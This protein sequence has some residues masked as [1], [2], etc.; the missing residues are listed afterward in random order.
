MIVLSFDCAVQNLGV[1]CLQIDDKWKDKL[2][3][4][5][6]NLNNLKKLS[7]DNK[8]IVR[9]VHKA[10]DDLIAIYSNIVKIIYMN[11]VNL[12][13]NKKDKFSDV[14]KKLKYFLYCLDK[15][16]PEPNYVL[17]EKQWNVN[18]DSYS[19]MHYIEGYYTLINKADDIDSLFKEYPINFLDIKP[20]NKYEVLILSASI[21]NQLSIN[22]KLSYGNIVSNKLRSNNYTTNK[23]HTSANFKEYLKQKN[24]SHIIKKGMKL[25][26]VSDAFMM[27]FNWLK[28]SGHI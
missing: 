1:C 16:L 5:L 25:D 21:K 8:E 2:D 26:D 3:V 13:K 15:Q 6:D 27:A 20:N 14:V 9:S 22:K 17:I 7:P 10:L 28:I 24:L 11:T 4:V 12:T 23:K 18:P 19:V